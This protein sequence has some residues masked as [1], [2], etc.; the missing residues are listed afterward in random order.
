MRNFKSFNSVSGNEYSNIV[1]NN[2]QAL[3]LAIEDSWIKVTK[4]ISPLTLLKCEENLKIATSLLVLATIRHSA[5]ENKVSKQTVDDMIYE[6]DVNRD[7]ELSLNEWFNWLNQG[8]MIQSTTKLSNSNEL[9]GLQQSDLITSL[10]NV[11]GHAVC[12]LQ[13][14]SRLSDD[15]EVLTS[16]FVAGGILSGRL[17][18]KLSESMLNRLSKSA[19]YD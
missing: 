18:S 3:I 16:A 15:P 9:K 4:L 13:I 10:H 17:C 6:A 19:R 8:N 14:S 2:R 5:D 11:L 7:G 12:T 1:E